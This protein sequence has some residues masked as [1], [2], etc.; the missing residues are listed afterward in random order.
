MEES[1]PLMDS[2][3]APPCPAPSQF[4]SASMP[5]ASQ[6]VPT[7]AVPPVDVPRAAKN[8][9]ESAPSRGRSRRRA[10]GRGRQPSQVESNDADPGLEAEDSGSNPN[11]LGRIRWE[12]WE[13]R[14]L[15]EAKRAE[16]EEMNGSG[17]RDLIVNATVK[18][19]KIREKLLAQGVR[20]TVKR[21]KAKWDVL[22][23]EYR[24]IKDFEK[25]TGNPSYQSL[26]V[27]ERREEN[28][29]AIFENEWIE[30]LD[31]FMLSRSSIVP[32]FVA[33]SSAAQE[34]AVDDS[35]EPTPIE[36]RLNGK[37]KRG[38]GE[39]TTFLVSNPIQGISPSLPKSVQVLDPCA[40]KSKGYLG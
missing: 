4:A 39:N 19:L 23:R 38:I 25:K 7:Q 33:D 14:H 12:S 13:V 3:E 9:T 24:K 17:A 35:E 27:D 40:S 16:Y 37:R 5:F 34:S 20:T 32:P 28:V 29:P 18:W 21:C 26:S 36:Q 10:G 22:I 11:A 6:S 15:L 8:A 1:A 30:I 31:G 2:Q